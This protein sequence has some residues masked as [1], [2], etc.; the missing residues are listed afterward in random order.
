MSDLD[1]IEGKGIVGSSKLLDTLSLVLRWK[2]F[3]VTVTAATTVVAI[4]VSFIVPKWYKA[5]A[6]VMPPRDQGAFAPFGAASS[7]LRG[8]GSGGKLGGLGDN[9]GVYNFLAILRSRSASEAIITKFDL[10]NVYDITDSSMEKTIKALEENTSFELQPDD[11]LTIEVLDKDPQRAADA[12][13]YYVEVLNRISIRLATQVA[14]NNREFIGKTLDVVR[15]DLRNAEDSL[16][17]FQEASGMMITPEQSATFEAIGSL[18]ALKS[19][20]EL[21]LAILKQTV[22]GESPVAQQI[23]VEV[24]ELRKRTSAIPETGLKSLRLYRDVV[25]QQKI[26]EFLVPLY[27]QAKIDEQKEVPVILVLDRAAPPEKKDRPHRMIIIGVSFLASLMFSII[28]VALRERMRQLPPEDLGK[29]NQLR[30]DLR[31]LFSLR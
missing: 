30:R 29:L 25:I 27:E 13:N 5:A 15:L 2:K 20:K 12:A 4:V 7:L 17:A 10:M 3:I 14:H 8:L 9:L 6:S 16:R 26:L 21:E 23:E 22:G 28:L 1:E 18:Y 31:S 24:S 11:Y 19:K